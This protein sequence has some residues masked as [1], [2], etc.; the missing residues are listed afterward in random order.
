MSKDAR[1]INETGARI[2]GSEEDWL[3]LQQDERLEF[4]PGGLFW[5]IIVGRGE[6]KWERVK[7][8]KISKTGDQK[9][10]SQMVVIAVSCIVRNLYILKAHIHK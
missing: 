10:I 9:Q 7:L 5:G 4:Y 3:P 1:V 8:R 6:P 2:A